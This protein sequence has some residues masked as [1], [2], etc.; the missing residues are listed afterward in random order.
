[1][2][3][4]YVVNPR[5]DT[6]TAD[7]RIEREDTEDIAY[8]ETHEIPTSPSVMTVDCGWPDA[9]STVLVRHSGTEEWDSLT[10][11][12]D[13]GC[14]GVIAQVREQHVSFYVHNPECPIDEAHCL[15]DG[16]E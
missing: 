13:E 7:V 10:T 11:S 2:Q 16:G 5:D 4:L 1:L 14:Q 3:K 8:L 12:D 9:P 15:V 6:L